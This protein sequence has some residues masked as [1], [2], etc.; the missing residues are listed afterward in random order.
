MEIYISHDFQKII[1]DRTSFVEPWIRTL[2]SLNQPS[3]KPIGP[4]G[5]DDLSKHIF[6]PKKYHFFQF[7]LQSYLLTDH[8]FI[9]FQFLEYMNFFLE[10]Y[11]LCI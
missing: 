3:A 1:L 7:S 5:N 10:F 4:L 8:W 6:E 2:R 11:C 9:F